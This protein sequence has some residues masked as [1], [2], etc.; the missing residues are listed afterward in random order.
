M[1]KSQIK[2]TDISIREHCAQIVGDQ[3][4]NFR[5]SLLLSEWLSHGF[6][7]LSGDSWLLVLVV[8]FRLYHALQMY[9]LGLSQGSRKNE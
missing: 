1:F 4:I 8:G 9:G 6:M 2:Q 5:E 3:R 7:P